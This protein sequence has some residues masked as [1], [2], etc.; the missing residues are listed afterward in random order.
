MKQYKKTVVDI[1]DEQHNRIECKLWSNNDCNWYRFVVVL[2][3]IIILLMLKKYNFHYKYWPYKSV[4]TFDLISLCGCI[5]IMQ[6]C[7][8]IHG[9][10]K[11]KIIV[12]HL[13]QHISIETHL[14]NICLII[15]HNALL[16]FTYHYQIVSNIYHVIRQKVFIFYW[17][18]TFKFKKVLME[19][20]SADVICPYLI[21]LYFWYDGETVDY[22]K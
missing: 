1:S 20:F 10:L 17:I 15:I 8:I 7:V 6:T 12:K 16:P 18:I 14:I 2:E 3:I 21:K 4:K 9:A 5:F 19:K 11:T 13:W 22:L